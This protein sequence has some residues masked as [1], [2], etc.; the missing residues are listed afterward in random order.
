MKIVAI[1]MA[2]NEEDI[3]EAFVRHHA[4]FLDLIV[5][6]DHASLDRTPEILREL[7]GEGLPLLCRREESGI[8]HQWHLMTEL[9]REA[10]TMHSA[11]WILALDVDEFLVPS[12]RS[13]LE[14]TLS[15]VPNESP[16]QL[17]LRTY[18]PTSTDD[19]AA[20]NPLERITHRRRRGARRL[21]EGLRSGASRRRRALLAHAG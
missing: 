11:D 15:A 2:R 14:A 10:S 18:I 12:E 20:L 1:T 3:L 17:P 7:A 6:I 19:P 5:A 4:A 8:Q 16:A 21:V 9:L 13:Q